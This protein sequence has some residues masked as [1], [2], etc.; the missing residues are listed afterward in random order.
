MQRDNLFCFIFSSS[1]ARVPMPAP[2]TA[3]F[4]A[5]RYY[6]EKSRPFYPAIP[7]VSGL[8][9][10]SPTTITLFSIFLQFASSLL[11]RLKYLHIQTALLPASALE[12]IQIPKLQKKTSS[13][14]SHIFTPRHDWQSKSSTSATVPG[15]QTI[16]HWELSFSDI[17]TSGIVFASSAG[18]SVFRHI[19]SNSTSRVQF[20]NL[21][22][23]LLTAYSLRVS[24]AN[25]K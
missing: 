6:L 7:T 18:N 19:S 2:S 4:I 14:Q 23:E 16:P 17:Y 1:G 9:S 25:P 15:I 10:T 3:K 5:C 22:K 24:W 12:L 20:R 13:S 21:P 8:F 11:L